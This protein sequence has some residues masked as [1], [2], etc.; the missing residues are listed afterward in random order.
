VE[1]EQTFWIDVLDQLHKRLRQ[2]ALSGVVVLL[3][4]GSEWF[5]RHEQVAD[6][7]STETAHLEQVVL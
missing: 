1:K 6:E 7:Q 2:L 5:F 3:A 4:V